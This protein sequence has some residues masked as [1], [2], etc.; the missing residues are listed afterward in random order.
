[1]VTDGLRGGVDGEPHDTQKILNPL[2][3]YITARNPS[4]GSFSSNVQLSRHE[5]L[6][7][8]LEH[9]FVCKGGRDFR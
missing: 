5:N 4:L 2:E 9:G 8:M 6:A 3:R 7:T 1:M